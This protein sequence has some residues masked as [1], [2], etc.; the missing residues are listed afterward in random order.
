[1]ARLFFS[2]EV[3]YDSEMVILRLLLDDETLYVWDVDWNRCV[4]IFDALE[5]LFFLNAGGKI[6]VGRSEIDFDKRMITLEDDKGTYPMTPVV[7]EK[8]IEKSLVN[9]S[10][11]CHGF[12]GFDSHLEIS[13]LINEEDRRGHSIWD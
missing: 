11:T 9:W 1:M 7:F 6:Q 5:N 3:D 10:I 4:Y 8:F 2:T 13:D 12:S